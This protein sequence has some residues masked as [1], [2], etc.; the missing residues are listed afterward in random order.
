MQF[1]YQTSSSHS[2]W[3][4]WKITRTLG[5]RWVSGS[6]LLAPQHSKVQALTSPCDCI[7]SSSNSGLKKKK[8]HFQFPKKLQI[9]PPHDPG[10]PVPGAHART[11]SKECAAPHPPA[12]ALT[13]DVACRHRRSPPRRNGESQSA[14]VHPKQQYSAL[15]KEGNPA[16]WMDPEDETWREISRIHS[17]KSCVTSLMFH[18]QQS[19]PSQLGGGG[20]VVVIGAWGAGK[21]GTRCAA[22]KTGQ[23][24]TTRKV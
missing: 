13:V 9:G 22:A 23:L 17:D 6:G 4:K 3:L 20:A 19:N 18:L 10:M 16:A 11:A 12:A 2:A 5:V 21:M 7:S 15:E 24:C 8:V 14:S 1:G